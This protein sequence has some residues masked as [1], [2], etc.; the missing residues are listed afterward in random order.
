[1]QNRD[2]TDEDLYK[3][4]DDGT[5]NTI[6]VPNIMYLDYIIEKDKLLC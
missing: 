6:I 1:M 4:L 2:K 5:V 3:A